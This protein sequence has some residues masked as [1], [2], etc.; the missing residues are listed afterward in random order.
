MS[1]LTEGEFDVTQAPQS[2]S[3]SSSHRPAAKPNLVQFMGL[4]RTGSCVVRDRTNCCSLQ[5]EPFLFREVVG[6]LTDICNPQL[7]HWWHRNAATV[8]AATG[9]FYLLCFSLGKVETEVGFK[10]LQSET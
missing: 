3:G 1:V 10:C 6:S 9:R 2:C 4:G 5:A 8:V 7:Q